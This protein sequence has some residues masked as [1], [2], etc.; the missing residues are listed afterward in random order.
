[1]SG[2]VLD[3]TTPNGA[4]E[5]YAK[6]TYTSMTAVINVDDYEVE[7]VCQNWRNPL[8]PGVASGYKVEVKDFNEAMIVETSAFSL[9]AS[10]YTPSPISLSDIT[11]EPTSDKKVQKQSTYRLDFKL[12]VP[13][14]ISDTGCFFKFTFPDDFFFEAATFS[15]F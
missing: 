14:M 8:T 1:M 11:F 2:F 15:Q 12:P 6:L 7:I 9:D 13:L 5:P 10:L 3:S 4:T